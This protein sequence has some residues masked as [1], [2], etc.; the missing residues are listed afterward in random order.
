VEYFRIAVIDVM[1]AFVVHK[2]HEER[3]IDWRDHKCASNVTQSRCSCVLIG[4]FDQSLAVCLL[5]KVYWPNFNAIV[6]R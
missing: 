4:L 5:I 1:K 3:S 2:L 6:M